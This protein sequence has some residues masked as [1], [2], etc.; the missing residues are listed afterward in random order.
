MNRRFP[1]LTNRRVLTCAI[2]VLAVVM[3]QPARVR[4]QVQIALPETEPE[5]FSVAP[6]GSR[7]GSTLEAEIRGRTLE[8]ADRVWFDAPGVKAQVKQIDEIDLDEKAGYGAEAGKQKRGQRVRLEITVEPSARVGMYS[9][10]YAPNQPF[11]L[12]LGA[13][14]VCTKTGQILLVGAES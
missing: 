6:L 4:M 9:P 14:I 7:R 3:L 2:T 11:G 10:N 13:K 8:G 1:G 5:V 12:V